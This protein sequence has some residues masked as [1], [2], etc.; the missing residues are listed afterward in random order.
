M[1]RHTGAVL[2]GPT[3]EPAPPARRSTGDKVRFVIRGVGQTLITFGVVVLLFVVYEVYITNW[4]AE[5]EQAKVH[6]KIEKVFADPNADDPT[7][8]LP[9]GS[10][11][12]IPAGTGIA[13]L[14][15]PRLGRDYAWTIVQATRTEDLEKGPG[16]YATTQMPGEIGNFAVAGHRVG[17]GQPFLNID[18]LK[19]GDPVIVETKTHWFVYRVKGD[20]ATGDL[21]DRGEDGIPGREIVDPGDGDVLLPVPDH[22]GLSPADAT[23]PNERLMTMTTCTPKF[24]AQQRMIVFGDLDKTYAKAQGTSPMP[25]EV[26]AFYNGVS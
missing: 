11:P 14:Y 17:K 6:Q 15:I 22:P 4:F 16:H 21:S 26:Q 1:G 3:P 5:R 25:A 2:D 10:I 8:K 7:L 24:S 23:P 19:P 13:N 20:I 9:D 18:H 12:D